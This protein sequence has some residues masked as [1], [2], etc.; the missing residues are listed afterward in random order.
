[1]AQA[2][3]VGGVDA[4][5]PVCGSNNTRSKV[6]DGEQWWYV[7]DNQVDFDHGVYVL[8]DGIERSWG[9]GRWYFNIDG[10]IDPPHRGGT[11]RIDRQTWLDEDNVET[12]RI[13]RG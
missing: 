6:H 4:Q 13:P 3:V 1:M 2:I 8:D 11:I 5:C 10:D 9:A 7:C 12:P